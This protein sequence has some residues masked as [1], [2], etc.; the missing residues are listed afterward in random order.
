MG[1]S[2][3]PASVATL[4][5]SVVGWS[6]LHSRLTYAPS[7]PAPLCKME[8]PPTN[9]VS[10]VTRRISGRALDANGRPVPDAMVLLTRKDESDFRLSVPTVIA[11]TQSR[12]DGRFELTPFVSD[13][14]KCAAETLPE[15][16]LWIW[17][18]GL[19]VDRRT[20]FG[21]VPEHPFGVGLV[22]ESQLAIELR[23]SD[24][25]ASGGAT[26]TPSFLFL[27]EERWAKLPKPLQDRLM[28]LSTS[29]GRVEVHGCG[30]QR[31]VVRIET[32]DFGTQTL[33]LSS[34]EGLPSRV[35][36]RQTRTL[37]G[38]I[39]LPEG[40]QPDLSSLRMVLDESSRHENAEQ[41]AKTP[42]LRGPSPGVWHDN[43]LIRPDRHGHFS[44]AHF[45]ESW[46]GTVHFHVLG[47]EALGFAN[48]RDSSCSSSDLPAGKVLKIA[49]PARKGIWLTWVVQD[50]Q[51]KRPL[52]GC[53][54]SMVS[55]NGF[56]CDAKADK[57]GNARVCLAPGETYVV[58]CDLPDDY[59]RP[60]FGSE[61][62]VT[63]PA[64][65]E[66]CDPPPIELIRSCTIT[67]RVEDVAGRC[68]AGVRVQGKWRPGEAKPGSKAA[69]TIRWTETDSA[70]RFQLAG[71]EAGVNAT[72]TA[73]RAGIVL[74][75]PI[76]I[77][78]G[79]EK[80]VRFQEQKRDLV[81]LSGRILGTDRKPIPGVQI[82]V[83]VADSPDPLARFHATSGSDGT[84]QTPAQFPT[85]L[86]YRLIVRSMLDDVATSDWRCP[87]V[88]GNR[89][90]DLMLD[91]SKFSRMSKLSGKEIVARVNN[92]PIY[93]SE[94]FER[95]FTDALDEK[96][97]T[98]LR[99]SRE[100][101]AGQISES[102]FRS[103]Q[104]MAIK[105]YLSDYV[106]NRV[107]AQAYEATLEAEPMQAVERAI[108]KEFDN[109][110]EKLKRDF[111]VPTREGIDQKLRLQ[112]TSLAGIRT[113]FR[114]RLLAGEYMRGVG[115]RDHAVSRQRLLAYYQAHREAYA[116]SE[117]VVWQ[118]LEINFDKERYESTKATPDTTPKSEDSNQVLYNK[119]GDD[120]FSDSVT[121]PTKLRLSSLDDNAG[122]KD[123]TAANANP[124]TWASTIAETST[125]GAESD[126]ENSS[127]GSS[128]KPTG[129]R[130]AH[131]LA[132]Y[133]GRKK[134]LQIMD[135]ALARLRK[136]EPFEAV[137]QQF[138]DGGEA[139][140]GGWQP[141]TR[142]E[143]VADEK[144]AA[145]LHRLAEG[146]TSSVI[147][148]DH[149][150]RIVRVSTRIPAGYK[151]FEEVE[152][153][154]RQL[155][156]S[157]WERAELQE[158][159][160]RT[161]IESAYGSEVSLTPLPQVSTS[162]FSDPEFTP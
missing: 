94:L 147:D 18:P 131:Q 150:V 120:L 35:I 79:D 146:V 126:R 98:L 78:A 92:L 156:T 80:P 145:A 86:K 12:V 154:I 121:K 149:S 89:F 73:V 88:S 33:D 4:I 102:D 148:T 158:L 10:D 26:V 140:Q 132:G 161:S 59:L 107:L 139:G 104:E 32:T 108:V 113:E 30:G 93:A 100:L 90:A 87:G 34:Q 58:R 22:T 25:S 50:S 101:A 72:L 69:D 24:G 29:D 117:K 84:I 82:I 116:T 56:L 41:A 8:Q 31:M 17:K 5:L 53:R 77:V 55:S 11:Q 99:A 97:L 52:P 112:G 110:V 38:Q 118:L 3:I 125:K 43:F 83:D 157:D 96:G 21:E 114:Y 46:Q 151:P 71:V 142:P 155:L 1:G 137:A 133:V 124:V 130:W 160:S 49:L 48:D 70:G 54:V 111:R 20:F 68:L 47:L 15:F 81:A 36:L 128:A 123:D 61:A 6:W 51:T 9:R 95:A 65:A 122:E 127:E 85:G 45:P 153:S 23:K 162:K 57:D 152:K 106:R 105:K 14:K 28:T 60:A 7:R 42:G 115:P 37:E 129:P 134:A 74:A 144:T 141:P 39:V 109:Y 138:S 40:A 64:G 136:G 75:E 135:D 13:L 119:L 91:G 44:V 16:E 63:I 159:Y 27:A 19:A 143:S 67:G 66:R 103:A 76:K 2:R 62:Y